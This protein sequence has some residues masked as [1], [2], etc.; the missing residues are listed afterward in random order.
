MP[1]DLFSRFFELFNQPGR[2]NWKLAGEIARHLAGEAEAVDPFAAEEIRELALLGEYEIGRV[3][4]FP[5]PTT[6]EVR[7]MDGRE[8]AEKSLEGFGYLAEAMSGLSMVEAL[9]GIGPS[10]AGMQIGSLAGSLSRWVMASFESGLPLENRSP[11][12]VVYPPIE[13]F[14]ATYRHDPRSVRLW[15]LSEEVAHRA[16]FSVGWLFDHL[17]QLAAAYGESI[18]PDPERLLTMIGQDPSTIEKNVSEAGGLESLL[19]GEES[20]PHREALEA[21]LAVAAGYRKLLVKR[22]IGNLVPALERISED[23]ATSR[24]QPEPTIGPGALSPETEAEGL[25]FCLEIQ[26]RYGDV[27]LDGIW[28][29]PERLP[30]RSELGDPIGWAAR[31]LLDDQFGQDL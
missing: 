31:V 21:L 9:P 7:V 27:A 24:P 2:I 16:L 10:I 13:S 19:A 3:A 18:R 4:P 30:K 8:W 28:L 6:S 15:V 5:V 25:R 29:G 14:T 23:R 22:A 20:I 11:M 17:R 26:R 12:M 1:E